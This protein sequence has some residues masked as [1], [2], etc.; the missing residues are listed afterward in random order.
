MKSLNE[1]LKN[2]PVH[3]V[4]D[5]S[6]W[7]KWWSMRLI[8]LT[9]IFNSIV[10]AYATLPSDW[11]PGLPTEVKTWLA[12]GALTSAAAAGVA[13]VIQQPTSGGH[14]GNS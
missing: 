7:K 6:N 4:P 13:R 5:V 10:L 14:G 12:V 3:L 9:T 11:L 2:S 8:I 1:R